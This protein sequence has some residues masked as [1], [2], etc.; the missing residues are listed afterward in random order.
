MAISFAAL[1]AKP[2]PETR[3]QATAAKPFGAVPSLTRLSWQRGRIGA[4]PETS[5]PLCGLGNSDSGRSTIDDCGQNSYTPSTH[6]GNAYELPSVAGLRMPHR[7]T[8]F[9]DTSKSS[10]DGWPIQAGFWLEWGGRKPYT[11][12][13]RVFS[14]LFIAKTVTS[15]GPQVRVRSLDANPGSATLFLT[16]ACS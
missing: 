3:N 6:R 7:V 11:L 13:G 12:V 10:L 8:C 16:I 1:T 4:P 15:R 2:Q 5:G 14:L 9:A